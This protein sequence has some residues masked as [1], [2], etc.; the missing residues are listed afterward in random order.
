MK[1]KKIAALAAAIALAVGA[2]A[3]CGGN[4]NQQASGSTSA[5]S[6]AKSNTASS[7][8]SNNTDGNTKEDGFLIGFSN[9]VIGN[10]WRSSFLE[11]AENTLEEYKKSGVISD[12]IL[13]SCDND[14][15]EQLN[16]INQMISAGCDAIVINPLS[17]ASIEAVIQ[18]AMDAGIIVVICNDI[19]AV[20]GTYAVS[21]SQTA[22]GDIAGKFIADYYKD[23]TDTV[24]MVEIPGTVGV[25][26]AS[27]REEAMQA[28]IA[29]NSNIEIIAAAPGSWSATET[30]SVMSTF[31]A[32]YSDIDAVYTEEGGEGVIYACEN[33]NHDMP[34][35]MNGDYTHLFFKLWKEHGLNCCTVPS[36]TSISSAAIHFAV[37][38]LQG[39]EV[40]VS[41]LVA[42]PFDE[43]LVNTVYFDPTYV[44]TNDG[45]P[46]AA[47]L[48]G[49]STKVL[50]LD[51]ALELCEGK[52][53]SYC[54]SVPFT[55]EQVAS[56]FK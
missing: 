8:E 37:L 56:Y 30:Q 38:Q 48:E 5:G 33:T 34:E 53:E 49:Y 29:E 46:D 35:V 20:E 54:L 45:D 52:E 7:S 27:L 2:L 23:A 18:D 24:L 10:A 50:S 51:D 22:Y 25:D 41:K 44:V 36:D 16:Q 19:I 42:N 14:T 11:N 40:D 17:S 55:Q 21:N 1:L 12:Y 43:T 9:P 31:C 3:G 6:E 15:T 39:K 47:Y 13:S 26:A 4:D 32:T 28:A